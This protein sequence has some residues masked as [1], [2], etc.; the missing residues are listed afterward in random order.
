MLRCC[1]TLAL[2]ATVF[3]ALAA[4]A[5]ES[6]PP[7]FPVRPGPLLL[8]HAEDLAKPDLA[9]ADLEW[10]CRFRLIVTNGYAFPAPGVAQALQAHGCRVF[11]YV[12]ANG[13]TATELQST[14]LPDGLWRQE[15]QRG[16]SEWLLAATAL[17]GPPGTPPSYYYDIGRAELVSFLAQRVNAARAAG[18]FDGTFFDYA[19]A[20]ALPKPVAELWQRTHPD[21]PYDQALAGF[22][23]AL[24]AAD[25]QTL[26]F[27][28][29]A[30]LGDPGL[31][32]TVDYDL[33][34]SYG[35]S[36]AWGP[37]PDLDGLPCP[38]S[39]RRPYD[40]PGGSKATLAPLLAR[41][42]SGPP[43]GGLLCLDYMRPGRVRQGDTW[44]QVVDIE[45]VY[46][47]YAAAALWG[48][49]SYC[50]GWYGLEYRGPLY[51]ADLG[52]PLGEGPQ[53]L[54]G[55]VVREYERGVVALLREAKPAAVEL[56]VR[57]DSAVQL[58]SLF[59]GETIR[60]RDGAVALRLQPGRM[61]VGDTL[62]PIGRVYLKTH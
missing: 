12:W 31:L 39:Y 34:E 42:R 62:Q 4:S 23:R 20:Y 10:Y 56:R 7:G 9:A 24:R 46:Y 49:E 18:G 47:S 29:Q 17:D 52:T 43:R 13:F 45:T 11:R 61:P 16:H 1:R 6:L 35:T 44:Q 30:V 22:F 21:L 32:P 5:A 54:E 28:N 60:V 15:L 26:I 41:L 3:C 19:G 38:L 14:G 58:Y 50:S 57:G 27:S 2:L 53:E 36:Y 48:L 55:V 40:G 8:C 51:F 37:Q 33:V 25:P 59:D